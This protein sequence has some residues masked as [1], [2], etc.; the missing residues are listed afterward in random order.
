M[1]RRTSTLA[2][3]LLVAGCGGGEGTAVPEGVIDRETFIATYVD[4]RRAATEASDF[5]LPVGERERILA[6]HGV[7]AEALVSFAEAHGSDLDY[8]N[9]IWIEVESRIEGDVAAPTP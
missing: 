2:L 9:A 5:Q 6:D 7:A 8:M 1:N 4:L 3:L